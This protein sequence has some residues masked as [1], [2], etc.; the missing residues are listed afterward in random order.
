MMTTQDTFGLPMKILTRPE[1]PYLTARYICGLIPDYKGDLQKEKAF[2]RPLKVNV[3]ASENK[4]IAAV[5]NGWLE[6]SL[7]L[8]IRQGKYSLIAEFKRRKL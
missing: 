6:F 2:A 5:Q 4:N 1:Q 8:V 7:S 3:E